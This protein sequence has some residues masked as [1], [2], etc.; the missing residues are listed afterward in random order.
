MIQG[1]EIEIFEIQHPPFYEESNFSFTIHNDKSDFKFSQNSKILY[2]PLIS[3]SNELKFVLYIRGREIGQSTIPSILPGET[4]K[5]Q[6]FKFTDSSNDRK[7]LS[8]RSSSK[9]ITI[10]CYIKAIYENP[11]QE[12]LNCLKSFI[13]YL[14]TKQ[15]HDQST[16]E[17]L[18]FLVHSRNNFENHSEKTLDL[19]ESQ[20]SEKNKIIHSFLK[21]F[22]ELR[23]NSASI[24]NE[25][26]ELKKKLNESLARFIDLSNRSLK[27]SEES[28]SRKSGIS[29]KQDYEEKLNQMTQDY[30]KLVKEMEERSNDFKFIIG[31]LVNEKSSLTEK[32]EDLQKQL[33]KSNKDLEDLELQVLQFKTQSGLSNSTSLLLTTLQNKIDLL[34]SNLSS[35]KEKTQKL[36]NENNDLSSSIKSLQSSLLSTSSEL[37]TTSK[38]YQDLE[39]TLT[40]NN[41]QI[42]HLLN[43][44]SN[45][46]SK[47]IKLSHTSELNSELQQSNEIILKSNQNLTQELESLQQLN[48]QLTSNICKLDELTRSQS[49]KL[50]LLGKAMQEKDEEL[51]SL[52]E[53]IVEIQQLP[54]N[55]S[56]DSIDEQVCNILMKSGSKSCSKLTHESKGLY[57]YEGHKVR[58]RQQDGNLIAN[59]NGLDIPVEEF[60][61]ECFL[62]EV[63]KIQERKKEKLRS[64]AMRNSK[65]P[66]T[67]TLS[68]SCSMKENVLSKSFNSSQKIYMNKSPRF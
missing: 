23:K 3:Q 1:I 51:E 12:Y 40:I 10:R 11:T 44:K 36:Q 58:I 34:E 41:T 18:D 14:T 48:T 7:Q 9:T 64:L 59:L 49:C 45:L 65:A 17:K 38:K 61:E 25:N 33:T 13:S 60:F 66:K 20:L 37:Y 4:G 53:I 19:L 56:L 24:S 43:E 2:I 6:V 8:T 22:H 67:K 31:K 21:E 16:F 29:Q 63:S 54:Q 5:M 39:S 42:L 52:K 55:P 47:L 35:E 32:N 15:D 46:E 28:N 27:E 68:P 57:L 50:E 30:L 62:K 26:L